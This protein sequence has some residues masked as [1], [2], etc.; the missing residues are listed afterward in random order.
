MSNYIIKESQNALDVVSQLFGNQDNIGN[1]YLNNQEFDI[2]KIQN[3]LE[4]VYTA[5]TNN[6]ISTINNNRYIFVNRNVVVYQL[7]E[8]ITLPIGKYDF[9]TNYS[10]YFG[11]GYF[12]NDLTN[13][14]I[15]LNESNKIY[16][17]FKNNTPISIYYEDFQ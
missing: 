16:S 14:T 15:Y 5:E 17:V 1:L 12:V 8:T 4:L 6:V 11:K 3:G 10:A 9:S 13:E 7:L 2:N